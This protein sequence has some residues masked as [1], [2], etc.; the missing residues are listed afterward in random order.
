MGEARNNSFGSDELR[1][2]LDY[3]DRAFAGEFGVVG[4]AL[5][6]IYFGARAGSRGDFGV[7]MDMILVTGA[8]KFPIPTSKG[9]QNAWSHQAQD[10]IIDVLPYEE[11]TPWL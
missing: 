8:V 1:E 2:E 5:T 9:F 7:P 4:S 3:M 10:A 11:E 6:D